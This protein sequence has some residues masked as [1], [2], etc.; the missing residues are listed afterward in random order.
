MLCFYLLAM[1]TSV[2]NDFYMYLTNQ[3]TSDG[4]LKAT[5]RLPSKLDLSQHNYEVSLVE[6]QLPGIWRNLYNI[7]MTV[8]TLSDPEEQVQLRIPDGYYINFDAL[9]RTIDRLSKKVEYK[10]SNKLLSSL[11]KIGK[12]DSGKSYIVLGPDIA[13]RLT[14]RFMQILGIDS[15]DLINDAEREERIQ[16]FPDVNIWQYSLI[17]ESNVVPYSSVGDYTGHVLRVFSPRRNDISSVNVHE[18]YV[19]VIPNMLDQISVTIHDRKG[20]QL[21]FESDEMVVLLHLRKVIKT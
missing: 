10:L 13:V 9:A 5:C 20:H 19:P 7:G 12:S 16:V 18:I 2:Q 8:R 11:V 21:I 14:E 17:A 15:A 1:S 6:I 3:K 4:V